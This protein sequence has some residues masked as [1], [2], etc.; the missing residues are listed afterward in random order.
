MWL[1]VIRQI[2][3]FGGTWKHL[4]SI[5]EPLGLTDTAFRDHPRV[6]DFLVSEKYWQDKLEEMLKKKKTP[7]YTTPLLVSDLDEL[8]PDQIKEE[9][10][11]VWDTTGWEHEECDQKT[12]F[13]QG[14]QKG[15]EYIRKLLLER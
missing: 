2:I 13:S 10:I 5:C 14:F 7:E 9:S 1:P 8:K 3:E 12:T 4:Q 15:A 6:N 11:R